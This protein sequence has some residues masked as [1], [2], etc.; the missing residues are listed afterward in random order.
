K[1]KI[2]RVTNPEGRQGT[3]EEV[4][5]GADVFIGLS[6]AGAVTA[7]MVRSMAPG[8]VIMAMAN[9]IPEIYP[10]EAL[11]AG[12]KVVCTGRSDYPNQINNVLAFPG[13]FRGALDVRATDIN[14]EMKLAAAKAIAD[15]AASNG[16]HPDSIIPEVWDRR[17]APM[18]AV[19][20]AGAAIETGVAQQPV[21]LQGLYD[22][23]VARVEQVWESLSW[24]QRGNSE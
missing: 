14:D 13:V 12:A 24:Q 6:V 9:P 11:A 23:T 5:R 15:L 2:A 17:V 18:V 7:D 20:V 21:P 1:E 22:Q 16:L 8:A 4:I 10:E 3:L 19:A